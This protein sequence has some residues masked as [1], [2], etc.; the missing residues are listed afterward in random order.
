MRKRGFT[1]IELLV[2]IAII[3]ILAAILFPVFAQAREQARKTSCLSN[4]KQ[5]GLGLLMYA[6]DYDE[7]SV[8]WAD[9]NYNK[10]SDG[11]VLAFDRLIQPYLKNNMIT[12]CPSD[13]SP[14]T[15]Q[16]PKGGPV[17]IRSYSMPGSMGGGW[18]PTT[19]ARRMAAV[20]KP[21]Q[22]I[23]LTERDNCAASPATWGDDPRPAWNWCGVNDLESEMA[24]RHNRTANFLYVDGHAKA[25][26]YVQGKNHPAN[27]GEVGWAQKYSGLYKFPGYDWSKTDG[28]LWGAYLPIPGG[29]PALQS[30]DDHV[31]PNK[32]PVDEEVPD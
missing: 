10:D 8:P 4:L 23:Y 21:A 7:Q 24:W 12:G 3:A 27:T 30:F 29:G 15:G 13:L 16:F 11:F 26:P 14:G 17:V 31:C 9:P 32:V 6:Q 2:V 20:P 18:C 5:Q 22:T 19:P 25:A 28:S 1:L